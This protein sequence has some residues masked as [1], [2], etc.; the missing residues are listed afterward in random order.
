MYTTQTK[1]Y[2]RFFRTKSEEF[3]NL[4]ND[5]YKL[6]TTLATVPLGGSLD[7]W[8]AHIDKE[9]RL[10]FP[11]LTSID[12]S[13]RFRGKL[14]KILS[15][16]KSLIQTEDIEL[17]DKELLSTDAKYEIIERIFLEAEKNVL[18][19]ALLKNTPESLQKVLKAAENSEI[20]EI[21]QMIS[22]GRLN[23]K[24]W[25][26]YYN[27]AEFYIS[28]SNGALLVKST[29]TH[30]QI[31][32]II[33]TDKVKKGIQDCITQGHKD[34]ESLKG[35]LMEFG[36]YL[37]ENIRAAQQYVKELFDKNFVVENGQWVLK[38]LEVQQV[39][40][41][42]KSPDDIVKEKFDKALLA[43]GPEKL[44]Q[45]MSQPDKCL[46]FWESVC[47]ILNKIARGLGLGYDFSTKEVIE[48]LNQGI[49]DGS[50]KKIE[51]SKSSRFTE[52]LEEERKKLQKITYTCL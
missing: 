17:L 26:I 13:E 50:S 1:K 10:R 20:R 52:M 3:K 35:D 39:S 41:A 9:L 18:I 22:Q 28:V 6:F 43:L 24:F 48:T 46:G 36:L 23:E 30:S 25:V 12:H 31:S 27:Y 15:N 38:N 44:I 21:Y 45:Y 47:H 40:N 34:I 49:Y 5:S 11:D 51:S 16:Y 4:D 14:F 37:P 33:L 19:F 42:D 7:I 29:Y 8:L 32:R 2:K